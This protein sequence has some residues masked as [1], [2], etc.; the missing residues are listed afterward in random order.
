MNFFEAM[1]EADNGKVILDRFRTRIRWNKEKGIFERYSFDKNNWHE[2]VLIRPIGD[3]PW[4]VEEDEPK[5]PSKIGPNHYE[6]NSCQQAY[7]NNIID[8]LAY[9]QKEVKELKK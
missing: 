5:L 6:F 1:R 9:L 2:L 7:L 8:F 4:T 3:S